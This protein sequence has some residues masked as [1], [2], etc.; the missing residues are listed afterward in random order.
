VGNRG[1]LIFCVLAVTTAVSHNQQG[2]P[3]VYSSTAGNLGPSTVWVDASQFSTADVCLGI[4]SAIASLTSTH[5]VGGVVIDARNYPVTSGSTVAC[6]VNPFA[7]NTNPLQLV[8]G[9]TG[10]SAG[11]GG[12]VVLLPG[13]TISVMVPWIV[14]GN[15]SVVGEGAGNQGTVLKAGFSS[16]PSPSGT[17]STSNTSPTVSGSALTTW[18]TPEL[19]LVLLVCNS[20]ADRFHNHIIVNDSARI[21]AND[22]LV[23]GL[24]VPRKTKVTFPTDYPFWCR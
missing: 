11:V 17:L 10:S 6:S 14:P 3:A 20:G 2:A 18:N 8:F 23:E 19:G 24:P 9:G 4:Q 5:D 21:R 15:W 13:A 16:V 12:G 1:L 7:T 22:R